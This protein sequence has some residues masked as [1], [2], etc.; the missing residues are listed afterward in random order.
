M[1][2]FLFSWSVLM[3]II[4]LIFVLQPAEALEGS[5]CT[6]CCVGGGS[7]VTCKGSYCTCG[8][9]GCGDEAVCVC[10]GTDEEKSVNCVC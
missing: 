9:G 8:N 5:G 1:R 10:L 7:C 4:C 3:T 6:A 2:K